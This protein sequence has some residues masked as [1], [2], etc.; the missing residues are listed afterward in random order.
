MRTL[1][2]ITKPDTLDQGSENERAYLELAQNMDVKFRLGWHVL[3]NRDY[4]TR[5]ASAAERDQTEIDFFSKGV[6]A[7]L[8][9]AH[10]GVSALRPRLSHILRDQIIDQLPSVLL[11]VESAVADSKTRLQKLGASRATL[12]EQRHHLLHISHTFHNSI[13]HAVGGMY[14]NPFFGSPKTE[15]C[16]KKRLRAVVQN[17]L[18]SFADEMRSNGR[19]LEIVDSD[20]TETKAGCISR[21]RYIEVVK[22]LLARTR[23]CELP[24]TYNPLVVGDLFKEQCAPWRGLIGRFTGQILDAARYAVYAA[25][26]DAADEITAT[27]LLR[28]VINPRFAGL[29]HALD[30]K[31]EEI[32]DPHE[33]GHPITYNHY[34]TDNV[35]K[36][37]AQRKTQAL[38]EV[39]RTHLGESVMQRKDTDYAQNVNVEALLSSLEQRVEVDMER[40]AADSAID[41]MEAYYKVCQTL[42]SL[43]P[44]IPQSP[45]RS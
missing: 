24:G 37:Q 23:G 44:L 32:L 28:E 33:N 13:N 18:L 8:D 5:N 39:F 4:T 12:P 29:K 42:Q 26:K 7:A 15:D 22:N 38:R 36:A 43:M 14:N 16:Y 31:I 2:L 35:Q 20:D 21:S 6:W 10:V 40:F 34:L 41:M 11:D 25:V 27:G 17:T 3:R 30:D 1:G 45:T 19:A 9:R